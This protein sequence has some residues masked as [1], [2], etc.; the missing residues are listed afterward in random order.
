M[1]LFCCPPLSVRSCPVLVQALP[2]CFLHGNNGTAEYE[3]GRPP[4]VAPFELTEEQARSKFLAWQRGASRL[5]PGGLLPP[6]GPWRLAPALL[7]FWLWEL[8]ARVEFAGSV[9]CQDK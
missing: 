3:A 7:P 2:L 6:G 9:G 4:Q 5:A 1:L 8:R